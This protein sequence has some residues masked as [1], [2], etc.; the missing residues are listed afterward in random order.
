MRRLLFGSAS[1]LG[2]TM[3]AT[4]ALAASPGVAPGG[5]ALHQA[6]GIVLVGGGPA[7]TSASGGM[8][9]PAATQALHAAQAALD[10]RQS[11]AA[12]DA[13]ERAETRM[14]DG[15]A[16]T[17]AAGQPDRRAAVNDIIRA[18]QAVRSGDLATANRLVAQALAVGDTGGG[19]IA[20]TSS[21]SA[22]E[23]FTARAVPAPAPALDPSDI[24]QGVDPGI[25]RAIRTGQ[26][27]PYGVDAVTWQEIA[28]S[29]GGG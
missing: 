21:T 23:P 26:G 2:L 11:A 18:R 16:S 15:A 29:G 19:T 20:M 3:G 27:A 6:G 13:L 9:D 5:L 25:M 1:L 24:P 28:G 7:A 22:N 17:T 10:R 8:A 12:E 14:L 4:F